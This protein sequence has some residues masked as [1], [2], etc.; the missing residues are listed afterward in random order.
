ML[1]AMR[2]FQQG[3]TAAR[4][5]APLHTRKYKSSIKRSVNII[6]WYK[7]DVSVAFEVTGECH[8]Y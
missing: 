8:F 5:N 3:I 2:S 7:Y 1:K 4:E 6:D